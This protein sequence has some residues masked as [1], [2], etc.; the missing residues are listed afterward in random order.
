MVQEISYWQ[1]W[2]EKTKAE[3]AIFTKQK[4]LIGC[5]MAVAIRVALGIFGKV[6]LTTTD[7]VRDLTIVAGCYVAVV[8]LAFIWNFFRAPATL[9]QERASAISDLSDK[10]KIAEAA[11]QSKVSLEVLG[12]SFSKI[13]LQGKE[14]V[15]RIPQLGGEDLEIWD[16]DYESWKTLVGEF[17]NVAGWHTEVVPFLQAG[18]KAEPVLGV[19][20]LPLKRE[21]RR[22]RMALHNEKLEDIAQRRIG[23]TQ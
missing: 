20:N 6:R 3:T 21:K 2:R 14:L 15:D 17:L 4:L 7:I 13:M 9:D 12:E 8:F 23:S 16:D 5:F 11:A 22:R 19:I 1:R 10:L 18:D